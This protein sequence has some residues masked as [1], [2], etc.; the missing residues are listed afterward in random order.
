M[1]VVLMPLIEELMPL[2]DPELAEKQETRSA[3]SSL[4]I[5]R[6]LKNVRI[7]R[8]VRLMRIFQ[9]LRLMLTSIFGAIKSLCWA[10]LLLFL[11]MWVFG[12]FFVEGACDY[13][14]D[15]PEARVEMD[16]WYGSLG[17]ALF[18]L[19]LSICGGMDWGEPADGLHQAGIHFLFAWITYIAFTQF[20]V[21]NIVTGIFLEHATTTAARD[22]DHVIVEDLALK[23][24]LRNDIR[25][26]FREGDDDASGDLSCEEFEEYLQD[27]RVQCFFAMLDLDIPAARDLFKVL[28]QDGNGVVSMEEFVDNCMRLRGHP[29]SV[30]VVNTLRLTE[31]LL[32]KVDHL[33]EA[34][35]EESSRQGLKPVGLREP[36]DKE[37]SPPE[38]AVALPSETALFLS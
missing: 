10:C 19:Y 31:Q 36:R 33:L 18:T 27:D 15:H 23:D 24:G 35:A 13:L 37:V 17:S 8:M 16:M 6:L 21:L 14:Q 9:E 12:V 32:A 11:I 25:E 22:L 28:D 2:V 38:S 20:A 3:S 5:L 4:R 26:L 1:C 34:K 7:I 29:K 30:D